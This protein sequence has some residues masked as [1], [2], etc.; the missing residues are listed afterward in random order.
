MDGSKRVT[1]D[2]WLE[3]RMRHKFQGTHC[4]CPL[5]RTTDE[6]PF[7][8]AKI[9]LKDSGDYIREYVAEC[10]NGRCEYLGQ[11]SVLFQDKESVVLKGPV[12]RTA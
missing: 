4:L 11:Y 3:Y 8:E 5:L 6:L 12:L 2:M 7:T 9:L 10:P 1:P